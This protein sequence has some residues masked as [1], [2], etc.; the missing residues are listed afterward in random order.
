MLKKVTY[1]FL[2]SFYL[3]F[4][5]CQKKEPSV[6]IPLTTLFSRLPADYTNIN[7]INQLE[8][9]EELNTY[10]YRNFYNGGGVGLG[11]INNDGLV[12]IYFCG[13]QKDN[14]L[15]INKGNFQFEDIT[16]QA[17]VACR[18][19]WSTGVSFADV[20]ADGWL[21]IYVCKSGPPGGER[22]YNELFINKGDAAENKGIPSFTEQA[23]KYGIGEEGLSVHAAFFDYDRDG[24][25]DMYLLNNSMR[26]VGGYDLRPGQRAIRDPNGG[27]KLYRNDS[28][29]YVDISEA[30]NIYGSNIGFGLGVTIGDVNQDGWLDIYVS[31]DFFERDYLYLNNKNGTFREAL[32]EHI[33]EISMGSMGADMADINN[34]G[35]P[36]IFVTDML[37]EE[38]ARIKTKTVFENWD[39]Y[40]LNLKNGY[41]HQFTRNVL[42]LNRGKNPNSNDNHVYFSEIGRMAGIHA[43]DWSWGALIMDMDNDGKKDI[44]VA[45]G[46]FQDLTDQDYLHFYSDPNNVR[47]IIQNEDEAILKLI[48]K[49]PS[50]ALP[51]YAFQQQKTEDGIP[52]FENK[53]AAWGLGEVSFSNGSAYGDLD[54]DG[55]LDLVVNNV[56]ML[57]FI[58][59]N[60]TD[61][62]LKNNYL[63]IKCIGEGQNTFALGTQ[64]FLFANG[65]IF[66]QELNPMRGFQSTVEH[67]LHFGLGDIA[68]LDSLKAVWPNGQ[69]SVLKDV[70]VNRELVLQQIL[71]AETSTEEEAFKSIKAKQKREMVLNKATIQ[72]LYRHIENAF[73][74]FDRDRLMYAMLST[75][76]PKVAIGDVN[77]DG[78]EDCYIGGAR[79]TAGTL[80][81]QQKNTT[82]IPK[83]IPIFEED[84]IAED[85]DCLFFDADGDRDLD[86]Y[87]ASGSNE[88]SATSTALKDRLYFNDG[89]GNFSKSQQILPAGK[90]ESTSCVKAAD[91]DQDGDQDLLIGIRLRPF[92][93]GIPVDAYILENDG[94]GHFEN[95][96]A[97]IAPNLEEIGMITDAAW[98]DVDGDKMLDLIVVGE[99]LPI[100][101][102]KNQNGKFQRLENDQLALSNGFWNCIKVADLDND[103]DEDLIL[104]NHGL[105]SRLKASTEKPVSMYI[106]DFD[107][108]RSA[109]QIITTYNGKAAYP[110]ALRH[111]L[112]MQLPELKKRY[113]KYENYKEQGIEDIFPSEVLER[114]I[115]LRAYE[116]RTSIALNDG[117]GNFSLSPLPAAAQL[118]PIYAIACDDLD[119]DGHLD[120]IL[121]GNFYESKPEIGIYDATYG[122]VLM[123][124]GSGQ[125]KSLSPQE[126]GLFVKGQIRDI[127]TIKIAEKKAFLIV[128][129]DDEV[130]IY[131]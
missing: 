93:Y 126:S 100:S 49:M 70:A 29:K 40:Q 48:A 82:F 97:D 41:Y 4:C 47:E 89:K 42:Q 121:G 8:Q 71:Q 94:S 114:A 58:Y 19:V 80:F 59:R 66:Y 123:G 76:G 38:E 1:L 77:G 67:R 54:N 128:K 73:S 14:R 27:N 7:F 28:G 61:T 56:N 115:V 91:Y 81:L 10:T 44:F 90:Y 25:L 18:G 87:V 5:S 65:Q 106:N 124:D 46:I 117:N 118:A 53:A 130:E 57:P 32:E 108:N 45:N 69:I 103:G 122:L 63:S 79:A 92:L 75:Q 120:L 68:R 35:R 52:I 86:L 110:L 2:L 101:V 88:F 51:N 62:L 36:E 111:D 125:F 39:K 21:D 116:M 113:L 6:A 83:Q 22:R 60:E 96:T 99:Y 72:L 15:Y 104:A 55:D 84:K 105:N 37:P 12:D 129:N 9:T 17:G 50:E 26:S 64:V 107:N 98:T 20:N 131:W 23:K 127:E 3:F 74:D 112:V 78:L 33:R 16:E 85:T 34:D 30:A 95:V 31:N 11:D 24:D 102:F 43:T 119:K 109:E 13:N